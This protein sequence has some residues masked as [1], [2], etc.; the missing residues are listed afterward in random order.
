MWRPT[1]ALD[2]L[3]LRQLQDPHMELA[4]GYTEIVYCYLFFLFMFEGL[5][6]LY[7]MKS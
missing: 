7:T 1:L 6:C 5:L 4:P 3:W 2:M